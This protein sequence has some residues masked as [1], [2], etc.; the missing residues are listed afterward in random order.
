MAI[1]ISRQCSA[2][3]IVALAPT[4]DPMVVKMNTIF[5]AAGY[6]VRQYGS[7]SEIDTI[8]RDQNYGIDYPYFCF[9]L[10]FENSGS[11][12][13]YNLRFNIT[14]GSSTEAPSPSTDI[15]TKRKLNI[16][17][18]AATLKSGLIGVTNIINNVIL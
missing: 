18:Y 7:D 12:Y 10:S 11:A 2:D 17:T 9:G 14:S 6:T 8:V 15:T 3:K 13:K 5:T 1:L 4:G 16:G